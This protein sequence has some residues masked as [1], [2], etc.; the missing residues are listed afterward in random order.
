LHTKKLFLLAIVLTV[1]LS[2]F[3]VGCSGGNSENNTETPAA[4]P[5]NTAEPAD[6]PAAAEPEPE[7]DAFAQLIEAAEAEGKVVV[8]GP[9]GEEARMALTEG[10]KA[11]YDIKVDFQGGR[12]SQTYAKLVTEKEAGIMSGDVMI[13]GG[14]TS[15]DLYAA[16][17]LRPLKPEFKDPKILDLNNWYNEEMQFIDKDDKHTASFTF[18]VTPMFSINTDLASADELT[19]A[20]DFIDPKWKGKIGIFDPRENGGGVNFGNLILHEFGEDFARKLYVEQ[21]PEISTDLRYLAD[22]LARG[23]YAIVLGLN[24]PTFAE[25]DAAGITNVK[26]LL[27]IKDINYRTP[28]SANISLL[29]N[30]PNPNAG[31]LYINWLFSE[32]GQTAASGL[33]SSVPVR[34]DVPIAEGVSENVVPR[35]G[36][37]YTNGVSLDFL[38][39]SDATKEFYENLLE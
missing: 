36:V 34:V 18:A 23:K 35:K 8:Y 20:A 26:P 33:L 11:K 13:S 30:S 2:V 27:D 12:S 21:E 10:F 1:I 25:L 5:A 7:Q 14:N 19:E 17:L 31:A 29:K 4:T 9:P 6:T 37:N 16:D 22:N 32:E 24:Q 28:S 3:M 15:G 39:R 38:S